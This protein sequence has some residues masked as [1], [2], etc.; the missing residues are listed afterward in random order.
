MLR[1][2]LLPVDGAL[3]AADDRLLKVDDMTPT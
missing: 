1:E 3:L 2:V